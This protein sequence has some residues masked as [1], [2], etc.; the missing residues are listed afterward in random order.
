MDALDNII[1]DFNWDS[2]RDISN[3]ISKINEHALMEDLIKI[4]S[5]YTQ[6]HQL[7]ARARRK[8][9]D[10]NRQLARLSAEL[11]REC[12]AINLSKGKKATA[13]DMEYFIASNDDYNIVAKESS[14]LREIYEMVRAVVQ[15]VS[16]KKDVLIQININN[17][18]ET[19]LYN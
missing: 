15:A 12:Q 1:D 10:K 18:E 11:G 16:F 4:P 8:Y 7:Q 13:K 9:E 17:R 14:E 6:W 5:I 19:K 3:E 2:F